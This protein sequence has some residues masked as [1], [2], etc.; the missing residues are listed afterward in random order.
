MVVFR[1]LVHAPI[2][3]IRQWQ[4]HRTWSYNEQSG[5]YSVFKIQRYIPK[6]YR[7][8]DQTNRQ[9]SYGTVELPE[10]LIQKRDLIHQLSDELYYEM[11]DFGIARE[12]AR[13]D[14]GVSTY[15]SFI[16]KTD[17]HNLLHF[18]RLRLADDAQY[19]TRLYAR[20][21]MDLAEDHSAI[22]RRNNRQK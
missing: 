3:V 11:I 5:R 18:L 7:L 8:Q 22:S 14:L 12:M 6:L 9:S 19:E 21:L 2:F 10:H 1:F 15:S 16:A 13:L 20:A 4:R 17:A